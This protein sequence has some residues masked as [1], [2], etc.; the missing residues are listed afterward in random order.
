MPTRRRRWRQGLSLAGPPRGGDERFVVFPELRTR[1]EQRRQHAGGLCEVAL[2]LGGRHLDI[3]AAVL[4]PD[5]LAALD[6]LGTPAREEGL[7]FAR[8][9]AHDALEVRAERL[10]EVAVDESRGDEMRAGQARQ[11]L[12]DVVV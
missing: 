6:V 4:R 3:L 12:G 5:L 2:R 9:F 10:H 1:G 11:A 7:G 8:L